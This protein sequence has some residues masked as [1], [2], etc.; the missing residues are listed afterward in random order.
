MVEFA[1]RSLLRAQEWTDFSGDLFLLHIVHV[2]CRY[3]MLQM[4]VTVGA[5]NLV[6]FLNSVPGWRPGV[7]FITICSAVN[8][9]RLD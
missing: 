8:Y 9:G 4:K 7:T 5:E 6:S 1:A 3:Q 2:I